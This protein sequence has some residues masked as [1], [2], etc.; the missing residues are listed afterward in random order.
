MLVTIENPEFVNMQQEYMEVHGQ[1]GYLK[2]EY[3]RQQTMFAENISSQKSFLKAESDYKTAV[4][5]YNGLRK[6][7][8]MLNISP[9]QVE[10]GSISTVAQL[11]PLWKSLIMI[12]YIWSFLFLKKIS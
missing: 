5:K 6:Q 2:S 7:L 1:L 3:E 4:A 10:A 12:I 9:V 8:T 11:H